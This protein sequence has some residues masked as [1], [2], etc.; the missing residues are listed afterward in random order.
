MSLLGSLRPTPAE[1][2]RLALRETDPAHV[3]E[4]EPITRGLPFAIAS[5][6]AI[7]A[8]AVVVSPFRLAM[9]LLARDRA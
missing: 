8:A 7:G 3:D 6:I 5:L 4:F 2:E 9:R 1:I